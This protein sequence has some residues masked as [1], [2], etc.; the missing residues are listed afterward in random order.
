MPEEGEY[1]ILQPG[2]YS[3]T[4][5]IPAGGDIADAAVPDV[6]S[7]SLSDVIDAGISDTA[8]DTEVAVSHIF[9]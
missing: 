4:T 9:A 5:H 7:T 2:S 8:T 3:A 6:P 1:A